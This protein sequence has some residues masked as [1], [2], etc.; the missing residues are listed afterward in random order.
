MPVSL[1]PSPAGSDRPAR[2]EMPAGTPRWVCVVLML[3]AAALVAGAAGLLAYAGGATVP[4]AIL[5]GGA[6][7]AGT[8]FLLLGLAHFLGGSNG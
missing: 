2:T 1:T 4:N 5:T 6:A 3:L 7:F 8:V